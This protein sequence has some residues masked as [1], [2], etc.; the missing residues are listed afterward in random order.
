MRDLEL[1]MKIIYSSQDF[2]YKGYAK[3][4]RDVILYMHNGKLYLVFICEKSTLLGRAV[5]YEY[6]IFSIDDYIYVSKD[7]AVY[8]SITDELPPL[9]DLKRIDVVLAFD[10]RKELAEDINDIVGGI[11]KTGCVDKD[12]YIRYLSDMQ[13]LKSDD[14][15]KIYEYFKEKADFISETHTS[16]I[17]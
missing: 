5:N 10:K 2:A 9:D 17:R 16:D 6:S 8:N 14:A 7:T 12:K 15:G 4:L 11:V 1:I 13:S 3:Y